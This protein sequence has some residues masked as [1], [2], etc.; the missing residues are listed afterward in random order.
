M[1]LLMLVCALALL[2]YECR[3]RL[4]DTPQRLAILLRLG[5]QYS[6]QLDHSQRDPAPVRPD[7]RSHGPSPAATEHRAQ[8]RQD[9]AEKG[10]RSDDPPI[11][12]DLTFHLLRE[13]LQM[14]RAEQLAQQAH[15]NRRM[16]DIFGK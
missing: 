11:S 12:V 9:S 8:Q 4:S 1:K 7:L 5:E 10:K 16:M 2:G 14:A 6:V 13:V 3:A 15:D